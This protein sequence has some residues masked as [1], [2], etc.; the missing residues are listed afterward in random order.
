MTQAGY[1]VT[2]LDTDEEIM[3]L[4]STY[5]DLGDTKT[6]GPAPPLQKAQSSFLA[7]K[8]V[9]YDKTEESPMGAQKKPDSFLMRAY[10]N[11]TFP[12]IRVLFTLVT[13]LI[14]ATTVAIMIIFTVLRGNRFFPSFT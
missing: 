1:P 2:G 9:N 3:K 7:F 12:S 6:K 10:L 8:R 11:L 4:K 13:S 5:P 14:L